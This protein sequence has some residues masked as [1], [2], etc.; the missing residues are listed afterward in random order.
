MVMVRGRGKSQRSLALIEAAAAI[1]TEIHPASIRAICYRLFANGLIAAMTKGETN[2]VSAQL[3]YARE[4][5]LIPWSWVVDETR[6]AERVSAWD[7]PAAF[8]ETVKRSYRRDRWNDQVEWI[9]VWS[10]KGTVRGTLAPVLHEFGLTFRVMHGYGSATALYAAATETCG[11][12]RPLTILYVGDWDPSGLHMSEVDLPRRLARYG[13]NVDV[14]RLALTRADTGAELPSF[15]VKT[16]RRDPRY[17]WFV[18]RYDPR[19]WELDAL[20]PVILRDRVE[21][22]IVERLDIEAWNRAEVVEASERDSL[23]SILNTWPGISGQ[24]SKY[25]PARPTAAAERTRG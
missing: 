2:R 25:P 14:V 6:E 1:L 24:A 18:D 22:A 13:G 19:C 11:S 12:D 23:T 15:D 5:G 4:E 10:E 16:K 7:D 21:A 20:S 8:V 17:R 9:E 3:T